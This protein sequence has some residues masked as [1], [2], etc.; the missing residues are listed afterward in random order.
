MQRKLT[1]PQRLTCFFSAFSAQS[2]KTSGFSL[3]FR[4]VGRSSVLEYLV[5]WRNL[6]YDKST[7]EREDRE[8]PGLK[9]EIQKYKDHR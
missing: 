8:I 4:K 2:L 7:W 1:L 9:E 3:D 5:K 6:P